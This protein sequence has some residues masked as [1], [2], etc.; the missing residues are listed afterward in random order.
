MTDNYDRVNAEMAPA[1]EEILLGRAD[2]TERL[3]QVQSAVDGI[4]GRG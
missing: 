3:A 4:M 2:A 1:V